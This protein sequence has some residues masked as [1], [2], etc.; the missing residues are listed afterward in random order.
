MK[1][2]KTVTGIYTSKYLLRIHSEPQR[3]GLNDANLVFKLLFIISINEL[4]LIVY[5]NISIFLHH[6]LL[7]LFTKITLMLIFSSFNFD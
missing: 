6:C 5:Q 3:N 1:N 2:T 7:H 4:F